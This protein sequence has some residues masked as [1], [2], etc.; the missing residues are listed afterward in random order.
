MQGRN[1]NYHSTQHHQRTVHLHSSA[2]PDCKW[3]PQLAAGKVSPTQQ[4]TAVAVSRSYTNS[5]PSL[6][7][8]YTS[9]YLSLQR[10]VTKNSSR[11]VSMVDQHAIGQ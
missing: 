3:P 10:H 1:A 5:R 6:V 8:T 2:A 9:P 7:T 4:R 11:H